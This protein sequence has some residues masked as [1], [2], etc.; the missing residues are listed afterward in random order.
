MAL[1][2]CVRL[3]FEE[4]MQ[5]AANQLSGLSSD[6]PDQ[7]T[8]NQAGAFEVGGTEGD[9]GLSSKKLVVGAYGLRCRLVAA[10]GRASTS[11]RPI[12]LGACMPGAWPKRCRKSV[13]H[14]RPNWCWVSFQAIGLAILTCH[15]SNGEEVAI[16]K[17]GREL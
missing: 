11:S 1:H 5:R 6:V 16:G 15:R 4:E 13:R 17:V 12:M 3:L 10:R 2:R 7:I 9:N 8:V 14:K